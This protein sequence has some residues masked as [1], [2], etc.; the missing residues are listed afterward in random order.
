MK[1]LTIFSICTIITFTGI[2]LFLLLND[3]Q[4]TLKE[5]LTYFPQDPNV[6]FSEYKTNL[7]L[8]DQV[9]ADEYA[10]KWTVSSTLQQ[11]AYLRQDVSL[12]YEDGRLVKTM[13]NW[14]ENVQ[15][16][17]QTKKIP[18]EDSGHFEA[19]SVHHAEM[20]YPNDTIKSRQQM[21][22]DSLYVTASPLSPMESFKIPQTE[23]EK[24]WQQILEHATMQQLHYVWEE[25]ITS[26]DIDTSKYYRFPLTYLPVYDRHTLP[27]LNKEQ[28]NQAVGGLLEG[29]Y[30]NY[31]FGIKKKNG[32]I[33]SPIGSTIP[34]LL[35]SKDSSHFLVLTRT[36]D[37]ENIQFIQQIK[38]ADS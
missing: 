37:G 6:S 3:E 9:D 22:Y 10:I 30:K 21:S 23:E 20:H 11:N 28:T 7:E 16:L 2:F 26:Y 1:R 35:L 31:F 4:H 27:G 17:K 32:E 18:R 38:P 14:K 8:T 12:L 5:S 29:L 24:E 34:L 33:V 36:P 13:S 15:E 25:L 19:V